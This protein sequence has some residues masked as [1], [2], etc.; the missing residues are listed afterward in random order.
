[1]PDRE[2]EMNLSE[3]TLE[4]GDFKLHFW[5]GGKP[6]APWVVLTHGATI[7][8]HEWDATLPLLAERFRV[9]AW[10][11]R[12]HGLSRP[13]RMDFTAA[14][15][16]L[17]DLLDVNEIE[18]AL[19]I[20]HSMGGNLHQEF[21]YRH[22]E[23]VLGMVFLG[24]TWNFQKLSALESFSLRIAEP[25]FKL[26]P[27]QTLLE[28]SLAAT[29]VSA[30]S[31]D[32]LR[33]AMSRLSKDEFVQI[34]LA[35]AACLRPEPDYRV[36][37]PLLLIVGDEDRTGNIRQAMPRWA[38]LEPDCHLVVIPK[39]RHAANLDD[40][41]AFHAEVMQFLGRFE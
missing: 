1:M 36:N 40:P 16:D 15:Q 22:P 30:A 38:A 5:T 19:F 12:A 11:V 23:R 7:D 29:A 8:H 13:A 2:G 26:Y 37:K 35:T 3:G 39:A 25:I 27:Y 24:C 33:A 10:D 9:L 21:V 41:A 6:G 18:R 4:R 14:A 34:M 32:L 20:G 31:R 28:Q 17:L